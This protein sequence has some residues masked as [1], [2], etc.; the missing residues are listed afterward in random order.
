VWWR[1]FDKILERL[2]EPRAIVSGQPT[3]N[4]ER[5]RSNAA[6]NRQRRKPL[7]CVFGAFQRQLS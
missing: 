6:G 2:G 5:G 4:P 3:D 7:L 1:R